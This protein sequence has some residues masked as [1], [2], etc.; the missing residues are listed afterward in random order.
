MA[1]IRNDIADLQSKVYG[2]PLPSPGD[3]FA[4]VPDSWRDSRE[5]VETGSGDGD[6]ETPPKRG[7][8]SKRSKKKKPQRERA[9]YDVN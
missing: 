5:S 6:K 2:Q 7:G 8:A 4:E 3:D 1:D 9:N